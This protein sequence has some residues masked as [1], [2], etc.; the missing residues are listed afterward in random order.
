MFDFDRQF[1]PES[2]TR[3]VATDARKLSAEQRQRDVFESH[4]HRVFAVGY[5][6]TANEVEAETILTETFVQAFAKQKEPDA[7]GVDRAL[8]HELEQRFSLEPAEPAT[9]DADLTLARATRRTDMEEALRVLPP[10]ERLVFLL[11]DVEGYPIARIAGLLGR[12]EREVQATLFSARIRI[13][14]ALAAAQMV[15]A[16]LKNPLEA[17]ED[18][19]KPEMNQSLTATV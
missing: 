10:A 18:Q 5:Y 17:R 11:K 14:N 19:D 9:P 12:S 7:G 2:T 6:M 13:R 4:R 8:L 1:S 3:L 16:S 15:A